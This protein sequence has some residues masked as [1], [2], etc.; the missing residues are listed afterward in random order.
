MHISA[1]KKLSRAAKAAGIALPD[2]VEELATATDRN[3]LAGQF[4][5]DTTHDDV[6][7]AL[8][9]G[10]RDAARDAALEVYLNSLADGYGAAA[11]DHLNRERGEIVDREAPAILAEI[12]A[13]M[14][15]ALDR[16]SELQ[17]EVGATPVEDYARAEDFTAAA[18]ARDAVDAALQV[19]RLD[20]VRYALYPEAMDAAGTYVDAP[21][22]DTLGSLPPTVEFP[23]RATAAWW[24]ERVAA[25]VRFD[26]AG[27]GIAAQRGQ[28]A[29]QI[30]GRVRESVSFMQ[31]ERQP[32][33]D[34]LD[35][36]T[37]AE[38]R[39]D[40]EAGRVQRYR[41]RRYLG[42][43]ELPAGDRHAPTDFTA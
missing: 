39:H 23:D 20:A 14:Y 12:H 22:F 19:A 10:D 25:G 4:M 1:L 34:G 37:P 36:R 29:E 6:V 40:T 2:N 43:D 38:V 35:R 42:E 27:P 5:T 28:R 16:L 32:S 13:A 18:T 3:R 7:R 31:D 9:A 11:M 8:L 24:R 26:F 41:E 33:Y 30:A 15:D 21:D 17:A